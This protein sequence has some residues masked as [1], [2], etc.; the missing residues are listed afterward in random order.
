MSWSVETLSATVD[1]ELDALP[2]DMRARFVRISELIAAVGLDKVGAPYV[3][4]LTGPLW[5]MRMSGRD[6]ISRALYVTAREQRVVVLRVFIK[7][8]RRTPRREI[9][10]ALQR[11]REVLG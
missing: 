11:A 3:R 2:I 7:K 5:E 9:D 10:L 1:E 6:G 8:T 4:H